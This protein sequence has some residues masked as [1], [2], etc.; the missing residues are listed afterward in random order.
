MKNIPW[1]I[2]MK[3]RFN[4]HKTLEVWILANNKIPSGCP[5]TNTPPQVYA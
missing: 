2:I 3:V 5:V 4:S 1:A